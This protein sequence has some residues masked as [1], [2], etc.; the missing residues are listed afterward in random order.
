MVGRILERDGTECDK[1]YSEAIGSV[2]LSF[3]ELRT[4]LVKVDSVIN[5]RPLT[6]MQDD[7]KGVN[8][9]L[10]PSHLM[11]GRTAVKL[12]KQQSL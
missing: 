1:E 10:T 7:S 3:E 9:A 5:A 4:L 11:Y 2:N 6:Y 12:T 8:Y